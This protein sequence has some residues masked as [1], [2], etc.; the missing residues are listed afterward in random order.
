MTLEDFDC[1]NMAVLASVVSSLHAAPGS[2]VVGKELM[3]QASLALML[4]KLVPR[5][6]ASGFILKVHVLLQHTYQPRSLA[7]N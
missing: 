7:Q 3:P 4:V 5:F 1:N 6:S 2:E